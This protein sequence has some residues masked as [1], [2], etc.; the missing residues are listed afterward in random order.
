MK[1]IKN[2]YK[3]IQENIE[4]KYNIVKNYF[5]SKMVIKK[6]FTILLKIKLLK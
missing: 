2:P 1:S 5:Q 4:E 6:D 3:K